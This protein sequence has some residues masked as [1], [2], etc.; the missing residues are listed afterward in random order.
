MMFALVWLLAHLVARGA[1]SPPGI[2]P[3]RSTQY[4][5]VESRASKRGA[6]DDGIDTFSLQ[7]VTRDT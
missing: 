1:G 2:Y 5:L 6:H 4:L 7:S 3:G